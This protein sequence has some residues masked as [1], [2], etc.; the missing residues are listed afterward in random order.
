MKDLG[1]IKY[2]L[3][4]EINRNREKR[5]MTLSQR[6]YVADL[7]HRFDMTDAGTVMTPQTCALALEPETGMTTEQIRAQPYPYP[8]LIGALLHLARGTR[9]DIANAVR[10]LSKFL[11]RYNE[12]HWI[13]ARRV[14]RYLKCCIRG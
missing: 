13:A 5:H 8:E 3:K 14:L 7:V 11:T 2:L 9:P 6:K 4:I 12:T 1:E 10:V